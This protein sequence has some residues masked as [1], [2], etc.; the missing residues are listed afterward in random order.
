MAVRPQAYYNMSFLEFWNYCKQNRNDYEEL[1]DI[2]YSVSMNSYDTSPWHIYQEEGIPGIG[3]Y[4]W[5]AFE[6]AFKAYLTCIEGDFSR[7]QTYIQCKA[8][9]DSGRRNLD[10]EWEKEW[11]TINKANTAS[12]RAKMKTALA[13]Q[14]PIF[15]M[16]LAKY[17]VIFLAACKSSFT[18]KQFDV[19]YY[20]YSN[21][22][23]L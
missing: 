10:A 5:I 6:H 19:L 1:S 14:D 20:L 16:Q 22:E 9:V 15:A 18:Q 3:Y 7:S 8:G 2:M 13:Y 21:G 23:F 4:S 17:G 12:E 11:A